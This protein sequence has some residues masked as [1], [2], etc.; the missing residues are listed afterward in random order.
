MGLQNWSLVVIDG[1]TGLQS[2][3]MIGSKFTTSNP[4]LVVAVFLLQ[5]I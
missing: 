5:T 2:A 3:F 4:H 1:A